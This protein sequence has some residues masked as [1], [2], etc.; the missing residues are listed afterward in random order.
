MSEFAVAPG[1]LNVGAVFSQAFATLQSKLLFFVFAGLMVGLASLVGTNGPLVLIGILLTLVVGAVAQILTVRATTGPLGV[2]AGTEFVPAVQAALP[3]FVP[4]FLTS[5]L[6]GIFVFLGLIVLVVP[7][8]FLAVMLMVSTV[9]CILEDRPPVEALKR[10]RELTRGNRWRLLGLLLILALFAIG[11]GLLVAIPTA[12]AG[13]LPGIGALVA[14]V[15]SAAAEGFLSIFGTIVMTHA[16]LELR[17]LNEA[18]APAP[19]I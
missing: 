19:L 7:G 3:K 11:G 1:K 6:V 5:L 4:V 12:A 10:S 13:I 15:V 8:V 14:R 16:F 2:D 17:R 18:S 9:A